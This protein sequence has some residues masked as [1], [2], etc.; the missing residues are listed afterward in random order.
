VGYSMYVTPLRLLPVPE[1]LEV[2]VIP[3]EKVRM[4]SVLPSTTKSSFSKL[5][6]HHYFYRRW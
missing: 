6:H 3:S 1:V 4:V 2:Q 5:I